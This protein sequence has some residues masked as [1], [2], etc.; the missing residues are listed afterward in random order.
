MRTISIISSFKTY[1]QAKTTSYF[2][3]AT[4]SPPTQLPVYEVNGRKKKLPVQ[5]ERVWLKPEANIIAASVHT[6]SRHVEDNNSS[7]TIEL[8]LNAFDKHTTHDIAQ[9]IN[10]T[11]HGLHVGHVDTLLLQLP[12]SF[13]SDRDVLSRVWNAVEKLYN[14]RAVIHLGVSNVSQSQLEQ[15]LSVAHVKPQIVQMSYNEST[16]DELRNM[17]QH[18]K[19]N[20]IRLVAGGNS[21]YGVENKRWSVRYSLVLQHFSVL[22]KH[23]VITS[24]DL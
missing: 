5:E 24:D 7:L 20:N 18:T 6:N 22:N 19:Q 23:G 1:K 8:N 11:M 4:T 9:A 17:I 3:M 12:N 10:N 13:Y 2:T 14:T 15:L 16:Q 21:S